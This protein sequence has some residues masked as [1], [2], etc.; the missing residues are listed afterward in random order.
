MNFTFGI[1]TDGQNPDRVL[2]II[3]SIIADVPEQNREIIVVGGNLADRNKQEYHH[4]PFDETT[5]PGWITRKKNLITQNATNPN[6]VYLHDY[7]KIL[8]GWYNGFLHFGEYWDICMNVLK[9]KNNTRY[10]DWCSW[11]DPVFGE[12]WICKEPWCPADGRI[13]HGKPSLVPYSYDKTHYMYVSGAYFIAKKNVMTIY[14]FNEDLVQGEGEDVEWSVRWRRKLQY[15]INTLSS[16]QLLKQQELR[17]L[18]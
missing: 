13:F 5:K 3:D 11:D 15:K 16:C 2:S 6:V 8:P 12:K 14:P 4:I 7:I 17:V 10:R 1:I 9:N 18:M